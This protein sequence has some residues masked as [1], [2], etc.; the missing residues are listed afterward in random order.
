MSILFQVLRG[1]FYFFTFLMGVL[2]VRG[3]IIFWTEIF[4]VIKEIFMPW[5]LIFCGI[6]VGYL[7]ALLWQG[8]TPWSG[9]LVIKETIFKKSFIV[10]VGIGLVLAVCYILF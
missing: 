9:D 8:K 1:L 3:D 7:I 6:M 10:G 5:Y 2:L 4:K